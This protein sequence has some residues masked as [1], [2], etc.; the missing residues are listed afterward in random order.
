MS[1]AYYD[2]MFYLCSAEMPFTIRIEVTFREPVDP[3]A[4]SEAANAA[5]RRYP[6]F[7]V[8]VVSEGG[9]LVCKPNP[10]PLTVCIGSDAPTLGSEA[11]NRH[12]LAFGCE[13]RLL[14]I[15]TSHVITDGAGFFPYIKTLLYEYLRRVCPV[16]PDSAGLPMAD[17]PF[18]PDELG[19]PFPEAEM[20]A[21]KPLCLAPQRD[22]FRLRDGGYVT[23]S[24]R[25]V[26]RFRVSESAVMAYNLDHDGSPCAL[27]SAL[28]VKAI[29]AL[30]PENE[31]D[32]VSAVSFNLRPGLGNAHSWRMLC[33]YI[34]IR[35]PRRLWD[36]PVERLCTC[37][38]GTV[39]LL[40]QP[41]NVLYYAQQTRRRMEALL[42]LPGVAAKKAALAPEALRDSTENTFSVSYVGKM[43]LGSLEAHLESVYNLTDGSTHQTA[44]IEISSVGGW[45]DV[46]F[47]QGFS[48]DVYYRAFLREL[49][50]CG[51]EPIEAASSPLGTPEIALPE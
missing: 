36:A 20:A 37:S 47:I 45:F 27:F 35:Y 6:Y 32:V 7:A 49:R 10:R 2:P 34:P 38:R 31:K 13:G 25:T 15:C 24:R 18:F 44:F 51:L 1:A 9:E 40:S 21:A 8:Q 12:L 5:V 46:A 4:L 26:Y 23:D 33:S 17:S 29:R 43:G 41:E 11:V 22:F 39:T 19:N 48:C 14:C 3:A 50:A 30:H 28:M 42:R 16:P